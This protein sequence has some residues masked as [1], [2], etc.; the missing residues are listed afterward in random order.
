[1]GDSSW[2][3]D[4]EENDGERNH[5]EESKNAKHKIHKCSQEPL[6][7]ET[8]THMVSLASF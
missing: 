2:V 8:T 5:I 7:P 3:T 6:W 1:M 4:M